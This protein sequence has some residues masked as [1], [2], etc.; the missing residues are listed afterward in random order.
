MI[1][2]VSAALCDDFL[3]THDN[4]I[5]DVYY[6]ARPLSVLGFLKNVQQGMLGFT[7]AGT[8]IFCALLA[9]KI[10]GIDFIHPGLFISWFMGAV[11]A[12]ILGYSITELR[13]L[14]AFAKLFFPDYYP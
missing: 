4:A 6:P 5:I 14:A 8:G 10:V 9:V 13:R 7:V 12:D 11:L 1:I 3:L 2:V